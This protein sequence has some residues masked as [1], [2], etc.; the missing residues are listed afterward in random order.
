MRF[1]SKYAFYGIKGKAKAEAS[2][3]RAVGKAVALAKEKNW[4]EV[5]NVLMKAFLN[6]SLKGFG[7]TDTQSR[8]YIV[9]DFERRFRRGWKGKVPSQTIVNRTWA[10][11]SRA[12][13]A[14]CV[15]NR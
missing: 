2:M 14:Y 4:D 3:S 10:A 1:N 7:S 6:T 15:L 5:E 9:E 11:S 8:E 12:W 13:D